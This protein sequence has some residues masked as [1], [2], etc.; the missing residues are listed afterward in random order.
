ML[1]DDQTLH[2]TRGLCC[3]SCSSLQ[4]DAFVMYLSPAFPLAC[5]ST[6]SSTTDSHPCTGL[7]PLSC[8]SL[9]LPKIDVSPLAGAAELQGALGH[10]RMDPI[11]AG[12]FRVMQPLLQ[13]S[14]R[15]AGRP[16]ALK[17]TKKRKNEKNEEKKIPKKLKPLKKKLNPPLKKRK[18]H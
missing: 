4:N 2:G 1:K 15:Q 14:A 6:S 3:R 9:H 16:V 11:I 12:F 18:T 10:V 8:N 17:K 13:Y 7:Q 5:L